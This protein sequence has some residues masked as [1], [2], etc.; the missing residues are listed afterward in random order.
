[1]KYIGHKE[2]HHDS[3]DA[4]GVLV[5]NLGTPDAPDR[6]SVRR[7]LKQFL[8]DPRVVEF[9]RWL[10]WLILNGIILNTRPSQSARAYRRIWTEN[11]SPLLVISSNQVA[12]LR[13]ILDQRFAGGI[14]VEL[15][16]SYGN[17]SIADG[18]TRLRKAAISR[19]IILP[20]YPQYSGS[21][22]GSVFDAVSNCLTRWRWV[23]TVQFVSGYYD[24]PAYI[25]ALANKVRSFWQQHTRSDRL[26]M[27]FHGVPKRYVLNGDP[28]HHH[29]QESGRLLAEQLNLLENQWTIVFQSRFGREEWLQ[30]YCDE[31]LKSLPAEGIKSVD[32][33]CPGFSADC[34]ETLEE[35]NMENRELFMQS[36]GE[37]FNYIDCLN[38]DQE[39][40]KFLAELITGFVE[41]DRPTAAR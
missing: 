22:I 34:L 27:S 23:P 8:S 33:M 38:D 2:I 11:G 37:Q 28:Y 19:L 35:I 29:C 6:K 9:P 15:G 1:M 5:V 13:Q 14:K 25:N 18:L 7:Y 17:P 10:W 41:A 31:R 40:L 21:T 3:P 39:H 30:P 4:T 12:G 32:L 36:G 24:H 26:L 20:L 16:M